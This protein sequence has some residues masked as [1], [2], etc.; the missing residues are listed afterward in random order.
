MWFTDQDDIVANEQRLREMLNMLDIVITNYVKHTIRNFRV[1]TT[2]CDPGDLWIEDFV[3]VPDLVAGA[4]AELVAEWMKSGGLP[5]PKLTLPAP[6]SVRL[7]SRP[8]LTWFSET[9]HPLK[10]LFFVVNQ[11]AASSGLTLTHF[12]FERP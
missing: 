7:R 1:G 9:W 8:V 4:S 10:R 3:S 12:A 6:Q 5:P 11:S 2:A